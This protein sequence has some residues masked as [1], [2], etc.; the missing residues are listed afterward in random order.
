MRTVWVAGLFLIAVSG[1]FAT[2]VVPASAS[3]PDD[4]LTDTTAALRGDADPVVGT[5]T[6]SDR[7]AVAAPGADDTVAIPLQSATVRPASVTHHRARAVTKRPTARTAA[8]AQPKK[9]APAQQA[10]DQA[11]AAA[12]ACRQRDPIARLL[13]SA[14][15]APRCA[16]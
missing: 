16:G 6:K 4:M 13:A 5:L 12:T 7:L 8:V 1:L 3:R 11:K 10:L 2:R 14:N 9:I 15:L